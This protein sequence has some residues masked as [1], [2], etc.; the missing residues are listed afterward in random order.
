[1]QFFLPK[2]YIWRGK[3]GERKRLTQNVQGRDLQLK[4]CTITVSVPLMLFVLNRLCRLSRIHSRVVWIQGRS[5]PYSLLNRG[6]H[7][8]PFSRALPVTH[9]ISYT[10]LRNTWGLYSQPWTLMAEASSSP[11]EVQ[12]PALWFGTM[13]LFHS[14]FLKCY[15]SVSLDVFIISCLWHLQIV[16]SVMTPY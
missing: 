3:W 6:Q 16:T 9:T 13:F 8:V 7:S 12:N 5:S 15:A 4:G 11:G 14:H 1:M 2:T 10:A